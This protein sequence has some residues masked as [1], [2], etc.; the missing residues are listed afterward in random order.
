MSAPVPFIQLMLAMAHHATTHNTMTPHNPVMWV[1]AAVA[2]G[3][4][5][6]RVNMDIIRKMRY[7]LAPP[8]LPCGNIGN[9]CV[10]D[11]IKN[12][13]YFNYFKFT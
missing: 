5:T 11:F 2:A 13:S 1:R 10:V 4:G 8:L 12:I 7:Q 3:S 9:V 6:P